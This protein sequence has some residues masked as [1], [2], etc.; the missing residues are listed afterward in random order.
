M[1][2]KG[3][4]KLSQE[5]PPPREGE[6]MGVDRQ[7]IRQR[8]PDREKQTYRHADREKERQTDRQTDRQTGRQ[9]DRQ[10]ERERGRDKKK[11]L[12]QNY[13]PADGTAF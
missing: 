2:E 12:N 8:Q 1:G 7:T 10:K 5:T 9:I 3:V 6:P 11:K 4:G 13:F